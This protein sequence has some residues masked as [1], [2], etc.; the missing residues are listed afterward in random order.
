MKR[1]ATL[2]LAIMML[3][4]ATA[5]AQGPIKVQFHNGGPK[6]KFVGGNGFNQKFSPGVNKFKVPTTG[7][8]HG[9]LHGFHHGHH[10]HGHHHH[11]H[12]FHLT[13]SASP[14][15]LNLWKGPLHNSYLLKHGK[16]FKYG[17]YFPG[18]FHRHWAHYIWSAKHGCYLF[19]CPLSHAYYYWS[20]AA[21]GYYPVSYIAHAAPFAGPPPFLTV[22]P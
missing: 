3:L 20:A 15:A 17:Y 12:G 6:G 11:H 18:K 16:S 5:A 21:G 2:S 14:V 4:A 19:W 13:K 8:P 1:Y 7:I 9:H 22:T 10:H